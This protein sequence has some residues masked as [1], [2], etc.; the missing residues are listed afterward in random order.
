MRKNHH[1]LVENLR[2]YRKRSLREPVKK[3]MAGRSQQL[4]LQSQTFT[5]KHITSVPIPYK[6]DAHLLTNSDDKF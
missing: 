4:R 3:E 2:G 6:F 1:P 5:K